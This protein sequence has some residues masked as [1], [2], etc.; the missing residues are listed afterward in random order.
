MM[1]FLSII[2]VFSTMITCVHAFESSSDKV[3]HE[4]CPT[5]SN[6]VHLS[7]ITAA[8]SKHRAKNDL[9]IIVVGAN[10]KN[11]HPSIMIQSQK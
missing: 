11:R 4:H 9:F 6:I 7:R 3:T 2:L 5:L 10:V 1:L 8:T